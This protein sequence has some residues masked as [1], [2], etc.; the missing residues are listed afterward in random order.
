MNYD[1][2]NNA[3]T[4]M[5]LYQ[6]Y[7]EIAEMVMGPILPYKSEGPAVRDFYNLVP[8]KNTTIGR[9]PSDYRL[10]KIGEQIEQ[11]GKLIPYD[12]PKTIARGRD[13]KNAMEARARREAQ[14]NEKMTDAINNL[15]NNRE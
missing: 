9:N 10:I 12:E 1:N 5:G 2:S 6:I 4:I 14:E 13:W 3:K 7:D 15:I 8:D 11:G